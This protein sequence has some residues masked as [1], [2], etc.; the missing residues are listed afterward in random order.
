LRDG[1]P[2]ICGFAKP[3]DGLRVILFHKLVLPQSLY[4]L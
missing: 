4:F 2:G 1:V 3:D